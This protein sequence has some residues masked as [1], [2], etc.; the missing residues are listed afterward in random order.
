MY[1]RVSASSSDSCV[2]RLSTLSGKTRGRGAPPRKRQGTT[3]RRTAAPSLPPYVV[4]LCA[5]RCKASSARRPRRP[6]RPQPAPE[7]RRGEPVVGF[8]PEPHERRLGAADAEAVARYGSL[9]AG[10][11]EGAEGLAAAPDGGGGG[12]RLRWRERGV[13]GKRVLGKC[14]GAAQLAGGGLSPRALLRL[15]V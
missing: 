15:V 8:V 6:P 14:Y 5:L 10:G 9:L 7:L 11:P 12:E 1:S 2:S 13:T 4:S 3:E